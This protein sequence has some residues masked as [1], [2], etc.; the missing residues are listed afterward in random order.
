MNLKELDFGIERFMYYHNL[1]VGIDDKERF[2][3]YKNRYD[4]DTKVDSGDLITD[5]SEVIYSILNSS[6]PNDLNFRPVFKESVKKDIQQTI[7]EL[8]ERHFEVNT[9]IDKLNLGY[10]IYSNEKDDY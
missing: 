3:I 1:L 7:K 9:K 6:I 5:L 4:N 2:T 8:I 10:S